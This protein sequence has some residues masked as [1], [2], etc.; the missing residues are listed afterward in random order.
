MTINEK[1]KTC[2]QCGEVF[3]EKEGKYWIPSYLPLPFLKNKFFGEPIS[4][5][6]CRKCNDKGKVRFYFFLIL[7]GLLIYFIILKSI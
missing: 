1:S 7:V 3:S 5:F 6:R 4:G 2:V